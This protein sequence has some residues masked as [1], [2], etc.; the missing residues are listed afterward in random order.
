MPAIKAYRIAGQ[1]PAHDRGNGGDA[2]SQQ[3]MRMVW[4][5][6]PGKTRCRGFLIQPCQGALKINPV[7]IIEK[8]LTALY[9]PHNNMMQCSVSICASFPW[10]VVTISNTTSYLN[11]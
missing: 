9:P 2:C 6:G 11:Q 3:Q 4:N 5:Q 10:Y 1:E 7:K 8:Y